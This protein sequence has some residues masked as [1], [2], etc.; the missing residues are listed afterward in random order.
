MNGLGGVPGGGIGGMPFAM[1]GPVMGGK[2]GM[3]MGMGMGP[4]GVPMMPSVEQVEKMISFF[5]GKVK[6]LPSHY[7]CDFLVF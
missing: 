3:G 5:G 2:G 6:Q 4:M 1:G 7:S